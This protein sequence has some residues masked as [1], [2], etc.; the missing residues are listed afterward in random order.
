MRDMIVRHLAS[1][2]E[3][4]VDRDVFG[5]E[6][7]AAIEALVARF[8]QEHL[9][10]SPARCLHWSASV[11]VAVGLALSDGR[12]VLLKGHQPQVSPDYLRAVERVR[13]HLLARNFPG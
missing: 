1:W 2:D 3:P 9:G 4:F 5:T 11:G 10:A 7:P 8:C 6:D 12:E 13:R